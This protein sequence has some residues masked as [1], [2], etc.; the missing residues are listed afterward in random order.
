MTD[1][2]LDSLASALAGQV[3]T[4][5]GVAGSKALQKVRTLVRRKS[6]D[7]S[8]TGAAL[9]AAEQPSA[10]RPEVEA[11]AQRLAE[12]GEQ[13][14]DFAAKLRSEG[15]Q[16]HQ[17]ISASSGGVTNVNNGSAEKLIQA[18]DIEGGITFN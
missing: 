9:E 1:P 12:A 11:L 18:R 13:D 8:E 15:A 2:F 10:G 17:E 3:A 5:L 14:P 6:E 7:D 4:A 16:V